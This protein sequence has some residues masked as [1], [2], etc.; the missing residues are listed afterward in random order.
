MGRIVVTEYLSLDSVMEAPGAQD[1]EDFEYKGW[2]FDYE[3]GEEGDRFKLEETL[4]SAALLL[5]RVTHETFAVAWPG[6]TGPM[7]DKL[8]AMPKYV[9][10]SPLTA[11]K[12]TNSTVLRGDLATEV[13]ALRE[14]IDGD[15][16]VHGS[17]TLVEGL[18]EHD[19]VDE[20]RLMVYL[21][22]ASAADDIAELLTR[23]IAFHRELGAATQL[24]FGT[25]NDRDLPAVN[26]LLNLLAFA[27]T[28]HRRKHDEPPLTDE[29]HAAFS[30]AMLDQG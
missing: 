4:E 30:Q 3:R 21:L 20:L 16:V 22:P 15:I 9:V 18:I 10:S 12:W 27:E 26:R 5:G 6:M 17:A 7:A 24:L 2:L 23:W 11:A 28:Y 1:V 19:L 13:T 29:E 25:L 14:R 8:N